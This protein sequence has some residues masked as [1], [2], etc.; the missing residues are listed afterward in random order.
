M[1]IQW[2]TTSRSLIGLSLC[3][4]TENEELKMGRFV[5][6]LDQELQDKLEG[7]T[8]LTFV[9]ACKLMTKFDARRKKK[10]TSTTTPVVRKPPFTLKEGSSLSKSNEAPKKDKKDFKLSDI[11]CY[12]CGG[13][14]HFKKDCPNS[15]AL[16]MQE[17]RLIATQNI[18]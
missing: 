4:V 5:A 7:Y 15:R 18:N 12:K 10:K 1:A 13:R 9:E 14:G 2:K 16:T 11:V 17:V 8:N 6:G 3:E